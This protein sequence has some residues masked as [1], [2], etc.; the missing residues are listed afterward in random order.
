MLRGRPC[1][2]RNCLFLSRRTHRWTNHAFSAFIAEGS[3]VGIRYSTVITEHVHPSARPKRAGNHRLRQRSILR[4]VCAISSKGETILNQSLRSANIRSRPVSNYSSSRTV[5]CSW[6][7][8]LGLPWPPKQQ[9]RTKT[10]SVSP[11]AVINALLMG[12]PPGHDKVPTI[13]CHGAD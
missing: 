6:A 13:R 12:R 9:S 10:L 7:R 8:A 11:A 4:G 1:D 3:N 5:L 2:V